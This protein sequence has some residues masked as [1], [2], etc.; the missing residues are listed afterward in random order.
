MEDADCTQQCS[1][2][3]ECNHFRLHCSGAVLVLSVPL[4]P[5]SEAEQQRRKRATPSKS[6][7]VQLVSV[8]PLLIGHNDTQVA[9]TQCVK[10]K[11]SEKLFVM[12][13]L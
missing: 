8:G 1:I 3:C 6:E 2:T 4:L 10:Q 13:F 9:E 12:K 7:S 11:K 5:A